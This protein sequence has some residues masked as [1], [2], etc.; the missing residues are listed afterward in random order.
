LK[1]SSSLDLIKS[2]MS[3]TV[4]NAINIMN[5]HIEIVQA[6]AYLTSFDKINSN[7]RISNV[8]RSILSLTADNDF[9]AIHQLLLEVLSL[10]SQIETFEKHAKL[11]PDGNNKISIY[12]AITRYQNELS[13]AANHCEKLKREI[14]SKPREI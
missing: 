7:Q 12:Q 2:N 10:E 3:K 13:D 8:S 14:R 4:E 1:L 6:K 9:K 11:L 5:I